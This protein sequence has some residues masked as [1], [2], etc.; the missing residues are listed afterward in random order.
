MDKQYSAEEHQL[1]EAGLKFVQTSGVPMTKV[2]WG[3]A[4]IIGR[5]DNAVY[6]RMQSMASG[7]FDPTAELDE[8][9]TDEDERLDRRVGEVVAARVASIK[10]YGAL[11]VVEGTTRALLLHVSE[12][13]DEYI[14]DVNEY[15]A[16]GD[17]VQAILVVST[18]EDRLAL[19]T[20]RIGTVKRKT[21]KA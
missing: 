5:Q 13:A 4:S 3:L 15:L 20:K 6:H 9:V 18:K 17:V 1:L 21:P 16:V 2:A 7:S 14:D 10:S 19:S 8:D 11:C 12:I